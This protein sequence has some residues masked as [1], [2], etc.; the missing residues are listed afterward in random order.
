MIIGIDGNEANEKM[1]VGVHQ[2]A[3]QLLKHLA[4]LRDEWKG[5]HS[6]IIYLKNEPAEDFPKE[7]P[8]WEY[9]VLP[10]GGM[11]ILKTLMRQLWKHPE[12]D[13]FFAPNHYLP[14][15]LRMPA[16]CSIMDLGYLEN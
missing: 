15:I 6:F 1:R 5:K 13:V 16:V 14:P 4:E 10:G 2:Y 12:P 9:R 3:F 8:G 11:W 7:F